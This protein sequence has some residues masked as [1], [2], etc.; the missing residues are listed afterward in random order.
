M[1][2]KEVEGINNISVK[3]NLLLYTDIL[4]FPVA[5]SEILV[6][7]AAI[8]LKNRRQLEPFNLFLVCKQ[9]FPSE[10][11]ATVPVLYWSNTDPNSFSHWSIS[12]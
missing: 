2:Q 3:K 7:S 8:H 12:D 1:Q 11:S 10:W 9:S 6:L 5:L 4:L